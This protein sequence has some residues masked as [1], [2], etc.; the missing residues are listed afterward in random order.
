MVSTVGIALKSSGIG[1]VKSALKGVK[2]ALI[3]LEKDSTAAV[4]N[5]SKTRIAI[6]K[7]EYKEREHLAK[8][9]AATE[10]NLG[11]GFGRPSST[12]PATVGGGAF[13]GIGSV[14]NFGMQELGLGG[15]TKL[16][17]AA[18]VA[19][20]AVGALF[21]ALK[22]GIDI[23]TSALKAFG[24]FMLNDII[25]PELD[26]NTKYKQLAAKSAEEGGRGLTSGEAKSAADA[27]FIRYNL[28]KED[29][30]KAMAA[31]GA[32]GGEGAWSDAPKVLKLAA[33]EAIVRGGSAETYATVIAGMRVKGES[34]DDT[35]SKYMALRRQGDIIDVPVE[36]LKERGK[37]LKAASLFMGGTT[38]EKFS[39]ANVLAQKASVWTA[40]PASAITGL[41]RFTADVM[42]NKKGVA[43]RKYKNF[44]GTDANGQEVIKDPMGLLAQVLADTHGKPGKLPGL[45]FGDI[46]SQRF[47]ESFTPEFDQFKNKARG[48][49]LTDSKKIDQR[50]AELMAESFRNLMKETD[51][52]SGIET[53]A[54]ER[55]KDSSESLENGFNQ[56]KQVLTDEFM[57]SVRSVIK[58]LRPLL[59]DLTVYLKDN[60]D[61]IG[62]S[63]D[64]LAKSFIVATE[65]M[66]RGIQGMM[67]F[68]NL[69]SMVPGMPKLSDLNLGGA[70]TEDILG[71]KSDP[72]KSLVDNIYQGLNQQANDKIY[73]RHQDDINAG[74]E[75]GPLSKEEQDYYDKKNQEQGV[76]SGKT[77]INFEDINNKSKETAS[78]LEGLK[79]VALDLSSTLGG[80]NRTNSFVAPIK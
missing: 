3:E 42:I 69:L 39:A 10:N 46:R 78:A 15:I 16:A 14:T 70:F 68:L 62:A 8:R 29:A 23:A 30:V 40:D 54:N 25:K 21:M 17:G 22:A 4:R 72:N 34:V 49:G 18:G 79:K 58:D 80:L 63:L 45:G 57:P 35:I 27:M 55:M 43:H 48:E 47:I 77:N 56:I 64:A 74:I 75:F 59:D 28:S 71:F 41:N 19:G 36:E 33:Q 9:A 44:I 5:A 11:R 51:T 61:V 38:A 52:L 26:L 31:Y 32:H 20:A 50:A 67:V 60:S 37:Q 12:R 76:S 66:A 53:E 65:L 6:L 73:R 13:G 2:Q 24:S 1:E 7:E